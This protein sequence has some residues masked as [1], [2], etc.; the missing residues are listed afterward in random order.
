MLYFLIYII[1]LS[2]YLYNVFSVFY[3]DIYSVFEPLYNQVGRS[4][5][6][7]ASLVTFLGQFRQLKDL[8][9]DR[10]QVS[11]FM[12]SFLGITISYAA[13]ILIIM[14]SYVFYLSPACFRYE[15]LDIR[16]L[17][18][19]MHVMGRCAPRLATN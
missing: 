12:F 17:E 3:F 15:I 14:M 5:A 8:K 9:L 13:N 18:G 11:V 6:N 2:Y 16:N 19:H 7:H 4:E 10:H 1:I